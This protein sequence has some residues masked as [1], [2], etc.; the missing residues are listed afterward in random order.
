MLERGRFRTGQQKSDSAA[1]QRFTSRRGLVTIS[2]WD[3]YQRVK[4][5]KAFATLTGF[6][7]FLLDSISV[8]C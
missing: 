1:C 8:P 3:A 2:I 7:I 5:S 6:K 4:L